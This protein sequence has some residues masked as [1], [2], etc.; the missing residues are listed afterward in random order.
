[1]V[2]YMKMYRLINILLTIENKRKVTAK[3]LARQFETS[4]R[5]IYRD[6]DVLCEAGIPIVAEPGP[7]GGISLSEG[8]HAEIKHFGQEDMIYLYLNGIGVRADKT[9]QLGIKTS[10][11]L[12]KLKKA[13]S[14]ED[15]YAINTLTNRFYIDDNPWWGKKLTIKYID[16][17]LQSIWE[18]R[19][20]KIEYKKVDNT[21]SIRIIRPYGIVVKE[22]KWY[23]AAYCEK[24]NLLKTFKCE[25]ID[26]CELLE[27]RYLIPDN[28]SLKTYFE[29]STKKFYENCNALEQYP[30]TLKIASAYHYLLKGYE[31]YR[32]EESDNILEVSLN[33]YTLKN[34]LD[35][36][37]N[38]IIKSEIVSPEEL[39]SAVKLSM[40]TALDRYH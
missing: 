10:S 8:Y 23:L 34:A 20:L 35:D 30:V 17:I 22:N 39:R 13:L 18:L 40:Q 32:I 15:A 24:S 33:M 2:I 1:M 6:I 9:S 11:S 21:S 4:I 37:W 25:R 26:Q 14:N 12:M 7:S 27:D 28:F 38:I 36:F 5:T 3:D 31:I 29:A 19:K 16:I